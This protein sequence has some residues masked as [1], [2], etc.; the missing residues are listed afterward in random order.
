MLVYR[1]MSKEFRQKY[2]YCHFLHLKIVLFLIEH[3]NTEIKVQ[4]LLTHTWTFFSLTII[5][6]YQHKLL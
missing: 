6:M 3:I 5:K 4:V 2:R 1:L